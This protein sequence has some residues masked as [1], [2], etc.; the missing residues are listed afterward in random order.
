MAKITKKGTSSFVA[1][2]DTPSGYS[3]ANSKLLRVNAGATAV[4]FVT[5]SYIDNVGGGSTDNAVVRFDGT[6]GGTV[7]N[8]GVIVDDTNN[9][10]GLGTLNTRTI[11]N[12]VDGPASSI[13]NAIVR[14]NG[15]GGK[16]AQNSGWTIDDDDKLVC[17]AD[18]N[19]ATGNEIAFLFEYET[20]K[21]S[22]GN[23]SGLVIN[24]TDT[25]SPGTSLF[26]DAQ[27]GGVSKFNINNNGAITVQGG[28]YSST[29]NYLSVN[30]PIQVK[31]YITGGNQHGIELTN[32]TSFA[33]TSG[34]QGMVKIT[35][36]YNQTSGTAANTD[37][38]INRTE[39]AVGSGTQYLI[40]AQVGGTSKV[41][42]SNK[43]NIGVNNPTIEQ[44][45]AIFIANASTAPSTQTAGQIAMF[46]I[47]HTA[48]D[49]KSTLGVITEAVVEAYVDETKFSHV[50]PVT[51]NGSEY[52]VMLMDT[53]PSP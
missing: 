32:S 16:T 30:V 6:G 15:T 41:L 3:G 47:D 2:T 17:D 27:V 33:A 38:L 37:L 9:I 52:W 8:S 12:W 25:A 24:Q 39:T 36:T 20:N 13:D 22:S 45:S 21:A 31:S 49:S 29:Y 26:F 48:A 19:D 42:I 10:T 44:D 4:E 5:E 18:L 35:P 28:V 7:Q 50:L 46:S 51:I 14:F 11:A 43:A 53:N 1:L 34:S 40:D 23:D